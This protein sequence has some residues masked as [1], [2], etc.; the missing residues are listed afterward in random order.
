[1]K[2]KTAALLSP[3]VPAEPTP[4][5]VARDQESLQERLSQR[6]SAVK[7]RTSVGHLRV[8]TPQLPPEEGLSLRGELEKLH[9]QSSPAEVDAWY[10]IEVVA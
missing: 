4:E 6:T 8:V 2:H 1:M 5:S 3:Q 9:Q 7:V 10:V